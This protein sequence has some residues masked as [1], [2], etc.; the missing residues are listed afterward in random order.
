MSGDLFVEKDGNFVWLMEL[1]IL[2]DEEWKR[3]RGDT[4]TVTEILDTLVRHL[5]NR[6]HER[7]DD[8][9]DLWIG[10]L[11]M[12]ADMLEEPDDDD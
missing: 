6:N 11:R 1:Y 5:E 8:M 9:T 10:W 7:D 2:T 3:M 12:Y 4:M